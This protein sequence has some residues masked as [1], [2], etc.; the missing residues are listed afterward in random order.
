MSM[1]FVIKA[2][3]LCKEWA[4]KPLFHNV[5]FEVEEGACVALVGRNGVGKTTLIRGLM[6]QIPFDGGTVWRRYPVESWGWL[7]QHIEIDERVSLLSFVR[8]GQP[9]LHR[10]RQRLDA[11][12]AEMERGTS[13]SPQ[14]GG[15]PIPSVA[16]LE[17][18]ADEYCR[19]HEQY[20]AQEG[21]DWELQVEQ[22][23]A[24]VG[25]YPEQFAVPYVNLSGGEKTRAQ[26]ARLMVRH[27]KV[28]ILDEPT[29][30]LD[31]DTLTWLEHWLRDYS[32]SV[33]F[34]SHD[35]HFIDAVADAVLELAPNGMRRYEGGYTAF[36]A[37]RE[38]EIKT[39]QAL[40]EKQQRERARL[41][42][43][44]RRYRQWYQ[45]AHD[46][47]GV[48]F[49]LRKKAEKNATR[50]KA[51]ERALARLEAKRVPRPQTD[52]SVQIEFTEGRFEGHSLLA[53]HDVTFQYGPDPLFQR[54]HLRIRRG[55]KMAV[56]G[57][58]GV[59][60]STLLKLITGRLQPQIGQVIRHPAL[61]IGYFAQE[62][63]DLDL[64]LT[65]LDT[66][67][68]LDGMTES[69]ARTVLAGFL[70]PKDQVFKRVGDLSMG[71]RCRVAFVKLYFSD[72]NLL[73][74]DEPSNYLDIDA[75][76]RMEE[77]LQAYPGA[78]LIVS[79]DRY[80]I[81]KVANGIIHLERRSDG[82]GTAVSVFPGT[83]D[84]FLADCGR[85]SAFPAERRDRIRQLELQLA[86]LI[87]LDPPED[88]LEQHAL[89]EEIRRIREE[90]ASL[91]GEVG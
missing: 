25:F 15:R 49:H 14:A 6:N 73:V 68:Q 24:R 47:A 42:E 67:L 44:I 48:N 32:G 3:G 39:Q 37:Q 64:S 56:T 71:E 10:L 30:H 11:L 66:L 23:L 7:E 76:E 46:A 43:A 28:L 88:D 29:N 79:H 59:G 70:F 83:Y 33:L 55:D 13:G 50:F 17:A 57:G 74:L 51:K 75:R 91:K 69:Y 52:P 9:Q 36:R 45:Q 20:L 85:L 54:L 26:F 62:L 1:S 41:L 40:Y 80:L 77:A 65:V 4:G 27:P 18:L 12:Q 16:R 86:Q 72:A 89:L 19:V 78:L 87:A 22:I 90:L 38:L 81:R 8:S 35:R 5:D 2:Q 63:D 84:E 82:P 31:M 53:F 21:Y 61:R 60:K 58:N 34:V